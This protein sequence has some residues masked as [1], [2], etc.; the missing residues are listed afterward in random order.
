MEIEGKM[1]AR[2]FKK[3][4]RKGGKYIKKPSYTSS[5]GITKTIAKEVEQIR[6][7]TNRLIKTSDSV[8]VK[9][10]VC[11]TTSLNMNSTG[12]ATIASAQIV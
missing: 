6:V 9:E 10:F 2:S 11:P 7:K 4:M 12:A 1:S 3:G 8:E 5:R